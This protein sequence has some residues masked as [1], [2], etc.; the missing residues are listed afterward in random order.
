MSR[1]PDPQTRLLT[2]KKGDE[3]VEI[4][5]YATDMK[6][7]EIIILVKTGWIINSNGKI[8]MTLR[9]SETDTRGHQSYT[10][11]N[12]TKHETNCMRKTGFICDPEHTEALIALALSNFRANETAYYN[13]LI[14]NVEGEGDEHSQ[15]MLEGGLALWVEAGKPI[16]VIHTTAQVENEVRWVEKTSDTYEEC[17]ARGMTHSEIIAHRSAQSTEWQKTKAVSV[18]YTTA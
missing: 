7:G 10:E 1:T 13:R 12:T 3:A 15:R 8:Q 2:G 5:A 14:A 11:C 4:T 6:R 16:T 17:E 18:T 9:S